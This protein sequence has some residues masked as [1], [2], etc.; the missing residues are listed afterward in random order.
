MRAQERQSLVDGF[1]EGHFGISA[2]QRSL[3]ADF[4][5]G[6]QAEVGQH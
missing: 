3:A 4:R 6:A 5:Q 2:R 1:L